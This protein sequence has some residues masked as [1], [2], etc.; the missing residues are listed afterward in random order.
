M[1]I[2]RAH[3]NVTSFSF[4]SCLLK[5]RAV[6]TAEMIGFGDLRR[7]DKGRSF[8]VSEGGLGLHAANI[9][10]VICFH[11][12][13]SWNIPQSSVYKLIDELFIASFSLLLV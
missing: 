2:S 13:C 8:H 3:E 4:H 6:T 1:L 9:H 7:Q 5:V 12:I 10:G 11:T